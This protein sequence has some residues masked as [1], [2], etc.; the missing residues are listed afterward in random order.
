MNKFRGWTIEIKSDQITQVI[1][2]KEENNLMMF[3]EDKDVVLWVSASE[4]GEGIV[5]EKLFWQTQVH[6]LPTEKKIIVTT[7]EDPEEE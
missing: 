4:F 6:L 1:V 3:D 7:I 5:F 2:D